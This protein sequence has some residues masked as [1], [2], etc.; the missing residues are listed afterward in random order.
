[1]III[2]EFKFS[3]NLEFVENFLKEKNLTY[4]ADYDQ[5]TLS[6][7]NKDKDNILKWIKNLNLDEND[8]EINEELIKD[9]EE[10]DK[11]MYNPY[12][13]T[14]GKVPFFYYYKKNFP[15]I[16]FTILIIPFIYL[17]YMI[18]DGGWEVDFSLENIFFII[19]Y[20]F[21]AISIIIQYFKYYKSKKKT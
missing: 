15:F 4:F 19:F 18:I 12:Y 21:V 16:I 20:L 5:L 9:Y 17:I 7:E 10:W 11:N 8:V 6:C 14:G 3:A 1:M 13:F 2:K